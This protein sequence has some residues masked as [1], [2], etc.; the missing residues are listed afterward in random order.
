MLG[1]H[2]RGNVKGTSFTQARDVSEV[3]VE[4]GIHQAPTGCVEHLSQAGEREDA[5]DADLALIS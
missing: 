4:E 3:E 5:R 2:R 1:H